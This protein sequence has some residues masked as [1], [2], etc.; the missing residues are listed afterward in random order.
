MHLRLQAQLLP[1]YPSENSI[2]SKQYTLSTPLTRQVCHAEILTI[3]RKLF[4][5]VSAASPRTKA[6]CSE[7]FDPLQ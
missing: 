7:E 1:R 2:T 3:I 4:G 5:V 6:H